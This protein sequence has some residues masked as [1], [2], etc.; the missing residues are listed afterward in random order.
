MGGVNGQRESV[1]SLH[2]ANCVS[3]DV[4]HFFESSKGNTAP[5]ECDR[6][7]VTANAQKEPAQ[8]KIA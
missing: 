1:L 4:S 8:M 6:T 5:R 3:V 7:V 2:A